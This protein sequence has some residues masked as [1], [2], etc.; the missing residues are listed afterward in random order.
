[1]LVPFL[2]RRKPALLLPGQTRRCGAFHTRKSSTLPQV[3]SAGS[4]RDSD[5]SGA[6]T[7]PPAALEN[8]IGHIV[9]AFQRENEICDAKADKADGPPRRPR[10]SVPRQ[11]VIDVS[12]LADETRHRRAA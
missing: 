11:N 6:V 3:S 9:E 10:H 8:T 5:Q 4:R 1:H 2:P 12:N 7:H